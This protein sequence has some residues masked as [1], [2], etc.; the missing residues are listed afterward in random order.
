[1]AEIFE[2]ST[3]D[4]AITNA[5]FVLG[6]WLE[7][8]A[9]E[10]DVAL[11]SHVTYF[12][13]TIGP[14]LAKLNASARRRVIIATHSVP[15]PNR[16]AAFVEVA[17]GEEQSPVPGHEHVLAVL[18]ESSVRTELVDLGEAMSSA[19]MRIG[20]TPDEAIKLQTES[21]MRLGWLRKE[22]VERFQQSLRSSFDELF[23][24][25]GGGYLPRTA[26]GGRDLIITW[27]TRQ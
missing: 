20:K 17:T 2:A 5:R 18:E 4:A 3:R 13:A 22:E 19:T 27:E 23:A 1:M 7:A 24:P 16:W 10:G 11:V 9:V 8:D 6:D 15:P 26:L 21:G 12:V 14:F 25:S